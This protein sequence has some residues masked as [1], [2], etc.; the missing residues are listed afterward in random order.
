MPSREANAARRGE[1]METAGAPAP[2]SNGAAGARPP[3]HP[4][5][6]GL[7][8]L[9]HLRTFAP[10]GLDVYRH[11]VRLVEIGPEHEFLVAPCGPGVTAQ[12]LAEA[13]G[14]AGAGV[15]PDG[16]LVTAAA[17]RARE[18]RLS[19]RLHYEHAPLS[20]LP[21]KDEVFDL[22]IGDPALGS[23]PEPATAV[24]ELVRVAKPHASV[25][26]IQLIWTGDANADRREALVESLGVRPLLLVEWKQLLRDAGVVDLYVEDWSDSTAS[27]RQPW[28][29]GALAGFGTL[30]DRLAV[31]LRAWRI[32]GWRGLQQA[33]AFRDQVRDLV[34]KERILGLSLIKGTKWQDRE[35][36]KR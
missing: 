18:A 10:A 26:L 15:D 5:A 30:G 16:N 21:Y 1:S 13:T 11:L 19:D 6:L 29:L 8:R 23:I 9:S 2:T 31:L 20:E 24:R 17:A 33:L 27:P 28:A 35:A 36:P 3:R 4:S 12:F 34:L 7:A 25:V 22:V 32:W 14:A